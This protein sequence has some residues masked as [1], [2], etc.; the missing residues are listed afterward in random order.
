MQHT[1]Q[2]I[3][4]RNVTSILQNKVDDTRNT[5]R[6]NKTAD[7]EVTHW[8]CKASTVVVYIAVGLNCYRAG[9]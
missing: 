5:A 7:S 8:T 3:N 9:N 6:L 1:K 4:R 2:L